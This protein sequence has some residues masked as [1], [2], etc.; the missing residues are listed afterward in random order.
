MSHAAGL[1][2]FPNGKIY[3]VE[4][5]GTSDV[6][7]PAIYETPEELR[8]RWRNH[9]RLTKKCRRRSDLRA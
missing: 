3:H 5:D 7:L 1:I 9:E 6:L 2:K 8:L 4:Y